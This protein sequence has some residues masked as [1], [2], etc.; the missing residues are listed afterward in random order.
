MNNIHLKLVEDLRGRVFYEATY[1]DENDDVITVRM[2]PNTGVWF[3]SDLSSISNE[4]SIFLNR[5]ILAYELWNGD[6]PIHSI[7]EDLGIPGK[8]YLPTE[9][10]NP[11]DIF[12]MF[13]SRFDNDD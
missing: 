13:N 2:L 6:I 12:N 4:L 5:Y 8:D 7:R 10:G 1:E 9:L 3:T 11:I